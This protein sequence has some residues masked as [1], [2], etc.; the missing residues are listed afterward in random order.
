MKH[1]A[2][3]EDKLDK[4]ADEAHH[5]KPYRCP[6]GDLVELCIHRCQRQMK[7]ISMSDKAVCNAAS[8]S[9]S[10]VRLGTPLD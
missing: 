10:A 6:D 2:Y 3:D 5:N 7:H 1:I 9:T 4:E 8:I